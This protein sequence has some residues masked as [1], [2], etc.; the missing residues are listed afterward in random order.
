MFP[1]ERVT[2]PKDVVTPTQWGVNN[3]CIRFMI[4]MRKA[5]NLKRVFGRIG[6]WGECLHLTVRVEV[7]RFIYILGNGGNTTKV[8]YI[9][10][11]IMGLY[12]FVIWLLR[13]E[14]E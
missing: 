1:V 8:I 9:S 11:A 5:G 14:R 7:Y 13:N 10:L 6:R 2:G 4:S 3:F 12:R